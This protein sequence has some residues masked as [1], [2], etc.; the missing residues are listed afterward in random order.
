[1]GMINWLFFKSLWADC[2]GFSV[3]ESIFKIKA[4]VNFFGK[5]VSMDFK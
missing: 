5:V 3:N 2:L 1:M 4:I